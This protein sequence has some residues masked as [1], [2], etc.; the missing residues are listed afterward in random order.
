MVSREEHCLPSHSLTTHKTTNFDPAQDGFG[1][2]NPV[3]WAPYR[4]GGGKLL[5]R[6]DALVYEKGLCFGMVVA[7]LLNFYAAGTR[8]P[9]LVE[10]PLTPN[11]LETLRKYQLRQFQPRVVVMTVLGWLASGGGRPERIYRRIRA[12][13]ESPDPHVLCFGP[14]LNR[15]FFSCFAQAHA[16]VPYRVEGTRVYVYDPNYPRDRGRFVEFWR[17]GAEFAYEGFRSREGWGMTLVRV[18]RKHFKNTLVGL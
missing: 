3:G 17:G 2:P 15:R 11:L 16:V 9:P 13:G 4:T 7:S 8:R 6:F 5:R 1:F 12:V 14:A 18:H 10:L